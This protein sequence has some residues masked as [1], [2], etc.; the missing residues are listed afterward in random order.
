[1]QNILPKWL[2]NGLGG[3]LIAFVALLVVQQVYNFS[4]VIKNQKPANTISVSADGKVTA[5]PDLATVDVGV[6][7][8]AATATDAKNQNDIKVNQ[9]IAFVKQQG[10]AAADIQT[11]QLNLYPQQSYGG[12]VMVSGGGGVPIVPSVP[13]IT[14]Y[15]A[16]QTVEIKIHGIDKD[17]TV[18]EK[19]LDGSVNNG[20]NEVDGV[21]FS[22]NNPDALQQQ[23]Q[24]A[25]IAN[26]KV[27][28]QALAKAAGLSLGKVVSVS[29]TNNS[30][31]VPM[32]YAVSNAVGLGGAA[33]SVAPDIQPGSQDISESMTVT[34]EVK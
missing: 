22:F 17:Q 14:G 23:A 24:E 18:L 10:I 6:M 20:A 28:A 26:A 16:Q 13:K 1:M 8:L 15:Q 33:K 31:P 34:F 32:P 5:T 30:L 27:K 19:V 25:A 29:E 7:T 12:G 9:V 21:N 3:L 2:V 4:Q 11:Q